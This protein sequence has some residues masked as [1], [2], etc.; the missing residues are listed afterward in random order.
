[1]GKGKKKQKAKIIPPSYEP[2]SVLA[3]GAPENDSPLFCFKH[4]QDKSLKGCGNSKLLTDFLF[5]LSK[6][7][8][9]GWK[10]IKMSDRHS[11]GM[12]KI[13]IQQII[14]S[15]PSFV[16]PDVSH[17][18][19]FRATGDNHVFV[20]LQRQQVFHVLFIETEFGDIY[21]H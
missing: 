6:L 12:E 4:L 10:E 21:E 7:G 19:V 16:T 15:L 8:Q 2:S 11:F 9:L 5:R 18:H 20:G 13:P 1:M 17:L 14:P 3:S